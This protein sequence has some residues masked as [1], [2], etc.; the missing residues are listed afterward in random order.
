[1]RRAV[2][3]R[4]P[5]A[6]RPAARPGR[7]R[8]DPEGARGQ[9]KQAFMVGVRLAR[10]HGSA[11]S[12]ARRQGRAARES[13]TSLANLTA[14][15]SDVPAGFLRSERKKTSRLAKQSGPV[16]PRHPLS[17]TDAATRAHGPTVATS[18][19]SGGPKRGESGFPERFSRAETRSG[20]SALTAA[21]CPISDA[22]RSRRWTGPP[23]PSA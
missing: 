9:P 8:T 19:G 12:A 2:S 20:S 3:C 23:G 21:A 14:S 1:M 10:M 13:E 22:L 17:Q 16:S 11:G 15:R 18:R 6:L 4:P 7:P 5:S